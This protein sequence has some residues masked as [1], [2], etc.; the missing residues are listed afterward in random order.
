MRG[1][2]RTGKG[3]LAR[4]TTIYPGWYA[5]RTVHI[6]VRVYLGGDIAHTGQLFVPDAL[7]DAVYRRAPYRRRPGRTTRNAT[8]SIFQNGGSRSMLRVAKRG[9]AYVGRITMGVSRA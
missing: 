7:T 6:H 4:F 5:G 1:I 3:G 2:Q 8:D 9:N